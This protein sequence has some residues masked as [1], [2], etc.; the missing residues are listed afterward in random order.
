MIGAPDFLRDR[1]RILERDVAR[2][3]GRRNGEAALFRRLRDPRGGVAETEN[4]QKCHPR[5]LPGT[6]HKPR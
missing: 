3:A 5:V 2:A 6:A 4:E 1:I